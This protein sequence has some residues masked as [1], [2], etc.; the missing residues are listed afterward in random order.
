MRWNKNNLCYKSSSPIK[1]D[2]SAKKGMKMIPQEKIKPKKDA[3]K[4]QND[5]WGYEI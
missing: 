3:C 1:G 4:I 5:K 2:E